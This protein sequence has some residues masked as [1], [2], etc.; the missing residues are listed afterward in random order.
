MSSTAPSATVTQ[1]ANWAYGAGFRGNALAL[2]TA[3]G[4]AESTGNATVINDNPKTQ[5]YSVGV[6]QINYFGSLYNGRSAQFGPPSSLQNGPSNAA[7][8]Y[9]VSNGGTNFTPWST[10]KNGAYLYYLPQA[11][12]AA[13]QVQ[14]G[15]SKVT[16]ASVTSFAQSQGG[17]TAATSTAGG[18]AGTSTSGSP[19]VPAHTGADIPACAGQ[20]DIFS[21]DVKVTTLTLTACTAQKLL[22]ATYIVGGGL[23]CL[24]GVV[25]MIAV[26]V[27][28][29]KVTP[30]QAAQVVTQAP[31]RSRAR[32]ATRA[33]TQARTATARATTEQAPARAQAETTNR[34]SAAIR[35]RQAASK[36]STR[37]TSASSSSTSAT[38]E[39]RRQAAARRARARQMSEGQNDEPF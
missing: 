3:V 14:G 34:E 33:E 22:G 10:F 17:P 11:I 4:M 7:A 8:A 38:S 32:A 36:S 28:G 26:G 20:P 13:N 24:G 39:Q 16:T 6:W 23:L 15:N 5:D 21:I 12:V 37:P 31:Q 2:A 18:T 30:L 19:Y 9:S 1:V 27:K 35:R 29:R 25:L